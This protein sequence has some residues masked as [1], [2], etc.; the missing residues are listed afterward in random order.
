MICCK[1]KSNYGIFAFNA[2]QYLIWYNKK[3][4]KL[5]TAR[6][7]IIQAVVYALVTTGICRYS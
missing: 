4:Q 7:V 6:V 1:T 5:T 3:N 2:I